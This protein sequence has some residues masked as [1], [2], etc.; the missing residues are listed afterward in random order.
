MASG[1]LVQF[2]AP[3]GGW[4][5]VDSLDGMPPQDAVAMD[6]FFPSLTTVSLRRGSSSFCS[7]GESTSVQTLMEYNGGSTSKLIACT[8]GKLFDVSSGTA[9]SLATGYA[10]DIWSW[11]NYST[12]GGTYLLAANDSGTDTP[13]VYDGATV[14]AVVV[15]GPS[16]AANLSQVMVYQQR[17]F[18]V[19][20]NT[21]SVWYTAAGAYQGAL[22]QFDFG[23]FCPRGGSIATIA[24]WTRD[25]GYGGVDDIFVVVTT[26]GEILLYIGI[27][28]SVAT[29]FNMMGR[30]QVGIP[31]AGPRCVTRIGPDLM[32][33]CQDG[34]QPL[35]AYLTVGQS[36]AQ[37]SNLGFKIGNAASDAVKNYGSLVGW[38]G[39]PY[40]AGTALIINVPQ[41]STTF[42]QHVVNTTTGAWC[43]YKGMNAYCWGLFNN[44]LYY[45]GASGVVYR[46]D[47]GSSDN[48]TAITAVVQPAFQ[49][50]GSRSP[51]K[52]FKMLKPYFRVNGDLS[53]SSSLEIDYS[54]STLSP[55]DSSPTAGATVVKT[56]WI[57]VSGLGAAC[58]P[59]LALKTST[60]SVDYQGADL[61]YEIG[62]VL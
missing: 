25:N 38:Q 20:R 58:S 17:V 48:G 39:M 1:R 62:G 40:P 32:L 3:L 50:P 26:K 27:N 24:T 13:I 11:Q 37:T 51:I 5:A 28:P 8:N 60:L 7:T 45:G 30:F 59:Q 42:W 54:T 61:L 15:V 31:V 4:N 12:A 47:T 35:S 49:A 46:A 44:N 43:R 9:S 52:Q 55:S 22:T 53:Y 23:P 2:P 18:Y 19:E 21:L 36:K 14:T 56:N 29:T 57:G 33:L 34:Y 41:D 16:S 6:N 10:K